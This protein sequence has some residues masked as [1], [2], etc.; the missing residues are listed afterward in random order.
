[1]TDGQ[2]DRQTDRILIARP[3]LHSMQRGKNAPV[4]AIDEL[5]AFLTAVF[6][7]VMTKHALR[8]QCTHVSECGSS[9]KTPDGRTWCD[10]IVAQ[11]AEEVILFGQD[12]FLRHTATFFCIS[13]QVEYRSRG[14]HST[15]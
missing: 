2:T 15:K 7:A 13:F 12:F 8:A 4:R 3:C 14:A 9:L 10:S 5:R 11:R 6:A 1:V